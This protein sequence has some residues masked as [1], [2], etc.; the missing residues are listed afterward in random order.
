M[1]RVLFLAG[2]AALIVALAAA[3]QQAVSGLGD[4]SG[5]E[6]MQRLEDAVRSAAVSCYAAEG[7][8]PDTLDYLCDKYGVKLDARYAVHYE[9]FAPNIA[10]DI[11]V[12]TKPSEEEI[13]GLRK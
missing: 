6:S 8:Y 7:Q 5:A 2:R 12:S 9:I 11:T 4:R 3:A 13:W 1:R 10:P